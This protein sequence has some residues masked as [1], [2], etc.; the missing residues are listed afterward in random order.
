LHSIANG[1]RPI[2][3]GYLTTKKTGER[4]IKQLC[5]EKHPENNKELFHVQNQRTSTGLNQEDHTQK[6]LGIIQRKSIN[7]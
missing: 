6:W 1:F 7:F 3:I 5:F 2:L 4:R